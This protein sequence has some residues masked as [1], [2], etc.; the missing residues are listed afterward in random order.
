VLIFTGNNVQA[1]QITNIGVTRAEPVR[2]YQKLWLAF[3]FR[4]EDRLID[5]RARIREECDQCPKRF[6]TIDTLTVDSDRT[7]N[8]ILG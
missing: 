8:K 6:L 5:G 1:N 7:E 4:E 3:V 2:E